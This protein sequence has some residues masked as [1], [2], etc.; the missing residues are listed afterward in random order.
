MFNIAQRWFIV[1]RL[2]LLIFI[3]LHHTSSIF[4]Q[5]I[6][7]VHIGI[8]QFFIMFHRQIVCLVFVIIYLINHP[9][10]SCDSPFAS[11]SS[12]LSTTATAQ[13]AY[14]NT[15]PFSVFLTSPRTRFIS[16][17][18]LFLSILIALSGDVELN[19]GPASSKFNVCTFNI[20]SFTNPLHHTALA[21]LA[22]TYSIDLFALTETWVSSNTT[23]A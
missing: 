14:L 16:T 2:I 15:I 17:Q 18:C 5:I 22:D 8:T 10:L 19:P 13:F 23:S 9:P 4:R 6:T 21:D 3:T 12:S 20:R 1:T 11:L 7:I